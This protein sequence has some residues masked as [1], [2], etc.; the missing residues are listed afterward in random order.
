MDFDHYDAIMTNQ[1]SVILGVSSADCPV[2]LL[3]SESAPAIA[4]VHSGWRGTIVNIV[5]KT[6]QA[7]VEEY[8]VD[9]ASLKAVIGPYIHA[10]NYEVGPEV[11]AQFEE[12]Y[13]RNEKNR[14]FLD[15]GLCIEDQLVEAG[16]QQIDNL[17]IDTFSDNR[18][19][20]HRRDKGKTG[21]FLSVASL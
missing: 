12:R 21:R 17:H 8:G 13:V 15:L 16:V 6:V 11:A 10:E 19:Y 3:V 20:S 4:L 7:M 18:F 5:P 14:L 1:S 2:I 9:P